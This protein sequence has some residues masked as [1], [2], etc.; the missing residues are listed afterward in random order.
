[1]TPQEIINLLSIAAAFDNRKP[2]EATVHA[3]TDSARRG[4]WTFDEASE[5]VKTY[6]ATT[7]AERPFVMPSHITQWIKGD[8]QDRAM[9]TQAAELISGPPHPRVVAAVEEVA[10]TT[11]IPEQRG[12]RTPALRVACPHCG[13]NPGQSCTRPTPKGP[14]HM[15][16]HPSRV[17]AGELTV[18]P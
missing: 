8:R 13:A 15:T 11:V 4:R 1:V 2:G 5:A 18:T 6:Y 7:T 12:P 9:R 10:K 17:E 16:P 14:K 3:W